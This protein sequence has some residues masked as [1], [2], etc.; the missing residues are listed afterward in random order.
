MLENIAPFS[1]REEKEKEEK[2]RKRKKSSLILVGNVF[3]FWN[4]MG[5]KPESESFQHK[6]IEHE[7]DNLAGP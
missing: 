7:V 3:F 4:K 2:R 5:K 1:S 6:R